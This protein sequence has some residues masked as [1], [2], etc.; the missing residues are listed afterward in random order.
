MFR[1]LRPLTVTIVFAAT[2][3]SAQQ[4]AVPFA[5]D[6]PPSP[7][8]VLVEAV[9]ALFAAEGSG[10]Y[11]HITTRLGRT[12][13][14]AGYPDMGEMFVPFVTD[15]S[16]R[17][18]LTQTIARDYAARGMQA[19]AL[20]MVGQLDPGYRQDIG[21]EEVAIAL[22]E[23]GLIAAAHEVAGGI[24]DALKRGR[25]LHAVVQAE[26][27]IGDIAAAAATA[28]RI[29]DQG[30]QAES[31]DAIATMTVLKAPDPIAAARALAD[32]EQQVLAMLA[33]LAQA[34]DAP[35]AAEAAGIAL[36]LGRLMAADG[37][38]G[39]LL[40]IQAQA[41][42]ADGA[43][44][45]LRR[46]SDPELRVQVALPLVALGPDPETDA[47]IEE[48]LAAITDPA[49]VALTRADLAV[50]LPD[51]AR[52]AAQVARLAAIPD[53][54][55]AALIVA[56]VARDAG[57]PAAAAAF[58]AMI[59]AL[60]DRDEAQRLLREIAFGI[61][62]G[63]DPA[64]AAVAVAAI[65]SPSSRSS[66]AREMAPYILAAGQ[67]VDALLPFLTQPDDLASV[68]GRRAAASGSPADWQAA[69]E[70]LAAVRYSHARARVLIDWTEA[71][72]AP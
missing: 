45:T 60:P 26:L 68:L 51:P 17:S 21:R 70:A 65:D 57:D 2:H 71:M 42:D 46:I 56:G 40:A 62:Q 23:A 7:D 1:F 61:A 12:L 35:Y 49:D 33:R 36:T 22:A 11:V 18:S 4:G 58:V 25:A 53:R 14:E 52:R 24:D 9:D 16:L 3:L 5:C 59:D 31:R 72:L 38:L 55:G 54:E 37:T 27:A 69:R 66:L 48:A 67:P 29:P 64:G 15:T 32:P 28:E 41:G 50:A 34:P 6:L 63:S 39:R 30:W 44:A 47:L 10:S 8:C 43:R 19:E 20:A 13:S